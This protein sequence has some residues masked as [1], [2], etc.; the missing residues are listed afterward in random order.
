[1]TEH[2]VKPLKTVVLFIYFFRKQMC[3]RDILNYMW[4]LQSE[5]VLRKQD[6]E[7]EV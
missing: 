5:V 2:Q 7:L 4:L 1:M 6:Q 3:Y